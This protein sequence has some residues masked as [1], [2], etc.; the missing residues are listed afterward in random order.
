MILMI[1]V[2]Y[3][4]QYNVDRASKIKLKKESAKSYTWRYVQD[5]LLER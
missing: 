1:L 2:A 4:M 3:Y 5:V